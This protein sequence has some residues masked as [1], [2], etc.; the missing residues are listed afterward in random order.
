MDEKLVYKAAVK[1]LF[2][3][4]AK[5]TFFSPEVRLQPRFFSR[6]FC[7]SQ[8]SSNEETSLESTDAPPPSASKPEAKGGGGGAITLSS[9]LS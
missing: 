2:N 7:K 8:S 3:T 1:E 6:D 5:L 9:L 4:M